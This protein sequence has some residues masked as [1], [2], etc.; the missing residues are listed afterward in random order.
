MAFGEIPPPH[1]SPWFTPVY[2]ATFHFGGLCWTLCYLLIAREG[3]RTK[4]YGMPMLALANNFA[5]EMVYALWVVDSPQEKT[6]MTIWMLIDMPIIY[7]TVRHGALE[8][9]HAPAVQRNLT[10][11]LLGLTLLFGAAHWSWQSW[12]ISNGIGARDGSGKADLTQMA[13]WA[14]SMCQLLVSTTSLAMLAVRQH[15]KGAG[16]SIWLLRFLGTLVGLNFNYGWAWYTWPE[17]HGYFMSAP[18]IFIWGVTTLCDVLY[19]IAFYRVRSAETAVSPPRGSNLSKG[20][21]VKKKL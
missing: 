9:S 5:W 4:S 14:V 2:E 20:R 1:V 16:W 18:A 13:Y 17:A 12:W 11:I 15:T 6:A 3:L 8:W 19:A 7:S 21:S 10:A